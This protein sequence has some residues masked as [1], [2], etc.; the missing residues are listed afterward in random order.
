MGLFSWWGKKGSKGPVK[1]QPAHARELGYFREVLSTFVARA[2][3]GPEGSFRQEDAVAFLA[4]IAAERCFDAADDIPL[5]THRLEPGSRIF[6]EKIN[7]LLFG[8]A[9]DLSWDQLPPSSA[10]GFLRDGLLTEG[11]QRADFPDLTEV[12]G[13]FEKTPGEAG[14]PPLTVPPEHGPRL[15][16]L[17]IGLESRKNVDK[18]F[19]DTKRLEARMM[20]AVWALAERTAQA[21]GDMPAPA[22]ARLAVE[23]FYGMTRTAPMTQRQG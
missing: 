7:F 13:R 4:V 19:K 1:A 18:I 10:L 20:S 6:S 14:P 12:V 21:R 11:F 9:K 22:A 5:R 16:P 17:R 15:D 3:T 2:L 23:V 8:G